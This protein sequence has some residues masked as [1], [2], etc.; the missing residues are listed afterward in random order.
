MGLEPG[1]YLHQSLNSFALLLGPGQKSTFF[2][3]ANLIPNKAQQMTC[4]L[5]EF[6]NPSEK[7]RDDFTQI[8]TN[9]STNPNKDLYT[10]CPRRRNGFRGTHV[11]PMGPM[12]W[13]G[14]GRRCPASCSRSSSW[15]AALRPP[16]SVFGFGRKPPYLHVRRFPLLVV[17]N[18]PFWVVLWGLGGREGG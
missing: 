16:A 11:H 1:Q 10:F 9:P 15:R 8:P 7:K 17:W 2:P 12:G 3:G 4:K 6:L 13:W 5:S 18:I 14:S